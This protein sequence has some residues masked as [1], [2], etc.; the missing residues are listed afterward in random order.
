MTTTFNP[1][2]KPL[3]E[4]QMQIF[5][6]L[7]MGEM[8]GSQIEVPENEKPFF[9]SVIEKR[10]EG[11]NLPIRFT[12]NAKY[13]SMAFCKVVGDAVIFLVDSLRAKVPKE[14]YEK[15]KNDPH[16]ITEEDKIEVNMNDIAMSVYPT[17][18]YTEDSFA[19][20]IDNF[21]KENK[22]PWAEIY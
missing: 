7:T 2:Y 10:I 18:Y 3:S 14:I 5:A 15:W 9:V 12:E 1:K 4:D 22:V 17:G 13:S 6:S 8:A 11:L 21:L 20:Y 16:S 19:D